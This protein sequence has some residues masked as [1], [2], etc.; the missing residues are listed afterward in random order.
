VNFRALLLALLCG[1][2][3]A[4][5]A[6]AHAELSAS[7][8][9]NGATVP[10]APSVVVLEF[11]EEV[12]V[13]FSTFKVY[14]LGAKVDPNAPDAEARQNGLA[15][16]LVSDVLGVQ[17]DAA[18]RADLEL[19]PDETTTSTVNLPLKA[20]LE[21]GIYVVMWRILS[22]DTHQTQGFLTFEIAR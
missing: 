19:V 12:E 14:P 20:G 7:N 18:A 8:P 2:S 21:P 11:S 3:I 1:A 9:E 4:T 22:V 16:S 6:S 13:P 5:V 15:G 17:N 10:H